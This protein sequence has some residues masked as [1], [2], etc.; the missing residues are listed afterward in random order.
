M[1]Q[2]GP[3]LEAIDQVYDQADIAFARNHRHGGCA[4]VYYRLSWR[5]YRPLSCLDKYLRQTRGMAE[6]REEKCIG[7][8][9]HNLYRATTF[10]WKSV[11]KPDLT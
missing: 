7:V 3:V 2:A 5:V 11:A 1:D 8:C 10:F 9:V 4:H 6:R